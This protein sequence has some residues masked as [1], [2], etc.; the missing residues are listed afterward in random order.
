MAKVSL[1]LIDSVHDANEMNYVGDPV[2]ADGYGILTTGLHSVALYYNM[3]RGEVIIEATLAITPNEEDWFPVQ[4]K[5][6][7]LYVNEPKNT[8]ELLL[9]EGNFTYMRV[10]VNRDVLGDIR[11]LNYKDVGALRKALISY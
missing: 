9:I 3:F 2:K 5:K 7:Q 8:V 6:P 1:Q 10:R 4:L 11:T